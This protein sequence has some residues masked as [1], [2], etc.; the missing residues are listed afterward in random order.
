MTALYE[1]M[2]RV[3]PDVWVTKGQIYQ[4]ITIGKRGTL[5]LDGD[6]RLEWFG[7]LEN[8]MKS[9]VKTGLAIKAFRKRILSSIRMEVDEAR[10]L[11]ATNTN[12]LLPLLL[13]WGGWEGWEG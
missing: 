11:N 13:R 4:Q 2:Y 8:D 5:V 7:D 3:H 12:L 10:K 1:M 9:R 6:D